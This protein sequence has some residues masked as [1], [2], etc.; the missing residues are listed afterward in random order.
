MRAAIYGAGSLGTILGA[1]ISKNG[2]QIDLINHNEKHVETLR[3]KGAHV[4]GTLDFTQKV[5]ALTD[6]R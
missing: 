3:E 6:R 4:V 2:G 1:F 5:T